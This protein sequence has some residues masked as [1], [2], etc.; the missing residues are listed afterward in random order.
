MHGERRTY[1]V[2]IMG[3]IP[4]TL[5]I[6]STSNLL[7]RAFQHE[8]HRIEGFKDQ[9]QVKRLLYRESFDDVDKAIA[10]EKQLKR[11][12]RSKKI[13]LIDFA[14]PHWLDLAGD[15]HPWMKD[16]G[17]GRSAFDSAERSAA[18]SSCSAQQDKVGGLSSIPSTV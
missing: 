4:G 12:H 13:A 11:W 2:Y 17:T 5:Y 1:C 3:S 9:Y 16:S 18:G 15:W 6:G 7:K 14:N 8:F 10:R